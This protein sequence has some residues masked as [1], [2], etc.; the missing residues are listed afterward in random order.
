MVPSQFPLDQDKK[1]VRNLK[2]VH[3][4]QDVI[5]K[6]FKFIYIAASKTKRGDF[7]IKLYA[8]SSKVKKKPPLIKIKIDKNVRN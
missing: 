7:K 6:V 8:Y 2:L 5:F 3:C 1:L 4:L